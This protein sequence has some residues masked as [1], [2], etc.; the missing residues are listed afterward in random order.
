MS[1]EQEPNPGNGWALVI[2]INDNQRGDDGRH[3]LRITWDRSTGGGWSGGGGGGGWGGSGGWDNGWSNTGWNDWDAGNFW[4]APGWATGTFYAS[5]NGPF[6]QIRIGRNGRA[7]VWRNGSMRGAYVQS[8]QLYVDGANT[9]FEIA[10]SG[11]GRG[12]LLRARNGRVFNYESRGGGGGGGWGNGGGS[13]WENVGPGG[14]WSNN[15]WSDWEGGNSWEAPGWA[16]GTFYRVNNGPFEQLRI[17]G[18]GRAAV[19]VNGA[20]RRAEVRGGQLYVEGMPDAYD[21]R[22]QGNGRGI[23]VRG[24]RG[25]VFNYRR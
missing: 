15:G 2:R 17:G 1:V 5:N 16:V 11:N 12:I 18:H 9:D 22:E 23:Q 19:W 25:N 10:N 21:L 8:G 20:I 4:S 3:H 7:A 6:E 14:G 24:P 13:G